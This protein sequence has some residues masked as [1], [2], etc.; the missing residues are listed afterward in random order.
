MPI[1]G[2]LRL[3]AKTRLGPV[4]VTDVSNS[5]PIFEVFLNG[6]YDL[7]IS[8]QEIRSIVDIGAHVG[9]F[10]CWAGFQAKHALIHSFEPELKNFAELRENVQRNRL[11]DRVNLHNAAVSTVA[12]TSALHVPTYRNLS[13]QAGTGEESISLEIE[14]VAFAEVLR[15]LPSVDLLKIDVEGAE[16]DFMFIG[17]PDWGR[18][19]H[20]VVECHTFDGHSVGEML[21]GLQ[22]AGFSTSIISGPRRAYHY[23]GDLYLLH[24]FRT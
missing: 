13:S 18:V 5:A 17:N 20:V 1:L 11:T 16:W 23:L 6:E 22:Q 7:P 8:W 9:S 4:I 10:T 19:K 12:G 2:H 15:S 3:K 24:G 14:T 21:H